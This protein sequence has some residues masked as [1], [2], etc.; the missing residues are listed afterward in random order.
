MKEEFLHYLWKYRLYMKDKLVDPDGNLIIVIDPGTYNRDAGP[1]FFNARIKTGNTIWA[2]NIEIHTRAS[3]FNMHGHQNDPSYNNVILHVVGENDKKAFNSRGEEI[4]TTVIEYDE[5]IFRRYEALVSNPYT[6]ACQ[7]HLPKTEKFMVSQ[8]LTALAIER[9]EEKAASINE[10]LQKT[11]NDWEETF[12]RMLCRYFGFR[13]NAEPFELLASTLPF[14]VIRK[15]SDNIFQIEALLFGAAGML[16]E[17]LFREAINDDYFRALI[18]EFRILGTKYSIQPLHGW[19]WKFSRLR[20]ANFPTIR[21]SQLAAMLSVAGGLFRRMLEDRDI[22]VIK[23]LLEVPASDYWNEHFVFGKKVR[24]ATRRTGDQA[25][26][27]LI[28]N[29]LVPVLFVYGKSHGRQDICDNALSLL[30]ETAPEKNLIISE[31]GKAG[32]SGSSAFDTQAL[33]QLRNEYCSRRRCLDCRIGN[34]LIQK[35]RKLKDEDEV[36]MEPGLL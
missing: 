5:E 4:L 28:I 26:D 18:K 23:W 22:K 3:H 27:I 21:I 9:L 2:G 19:I 7:E 11:G 1:D 15:H 32:F 12:Y 24:H 14:R 25:T 31:W 35:G 16:E 20:P 34:E 33:L 10:I 13:V 6:I 30:E 36:M 8:W 17:K 29:A